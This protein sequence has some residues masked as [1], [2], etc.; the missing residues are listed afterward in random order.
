MTALPEQRETF[1]PGSVGPASSD[2]DL[3]AWRDAASTGDLPTPV[4]DRW[5]VLRCG[6]VN[7]WEF[8]VAEYWF[9]DGRAQFVGQNQSG[10]STLMALTTLIML[11]GDLDR[12]LVDTFGMQHKSFRYYVEPTDDPT[13]RRGT[14]HGTARGWAWVEY[15]RLV[16]GEP[17]YFTT[18][19]Y[20]QAK[21]GANDY[22]KAWATCEGSARVGDGLRLHRNAATAQP[23]DLTDV[24]GYSTASGGKEYKLRVSQRLF[25]FEDTERL[26][27]VVRMLKVLR[28][29]HLGQKLDPD[30]FTAR[31]R[32]A[33][34]AVSKSEIDELAE[35]WEQ[36]DRLAADRDSAQNARDAVSAYVRRAWNP[37][38]DSVL[39]RHADVLVAANTRQDSIA[40]GVRDAEQTLAGAMAG[41]QD[42]TARLDAGGREL[43]RDDASYEQLLQSRAYLDAHDATANVER[44]MLAARSHRV[45]A[46]NARE[47][48]GEGRLRV[49]SR[50]AT[51]AHETEA[52]TGLRNAQDDAVRVVTADALASGLPAE[53]GQ[54]A[55]DV[56]VARLGAAVA[57]RHEHLGVARRL[58]GRA[59]RASVAEDE[60]ARLAR[61]A[62]TELARR[63][64]TSEDAEAT[65]QSRLQELSD[66]LEQ[67]A[68]FVGVDAPDGAERSSWV[69]AVTEQAGRAAPR[70]VLGALLRSRWLTPTT[71]P[72]REQ[73]ALAD[74]AALELSGR[75][76]GLDMQVRALLD[77]RD[78]APAAPTRWTRRRR[79][80]HGRA[81][82][83]LWRLLDPSPDLSPEHLDRIEAALD[84]CGLL[85]AWVTPDGA[86]LP[87]RDGFDTVVTLSGDDAVASGPVPV[88]HSLSGPLRPAED[89]G[90]CAGTI[91]ALLSAVGFSLDGDLTSSYAIAADGR[92]R[93]PRSCGRA[94]PAEHGAELIGTAARASTRARKVAELRAEATALRAR[95]E[96]H[97]SLVTTLRSRVADL[98]AAVGRAPTDDAVV[99]AGL[100]VVA[101]RRELEVARGREA[102][103]QE[104]FLVAQAAAADANTSCSRS[105]LIMR[106]LTTSRDWPQ[107]ARRSPGPQVPWRRSASRRPGWRPAPTARP[108]LSPCSAR[109]RASSSGSSRP[110]RR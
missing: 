94:A 87:A 102:R 71:T 97:R 15:S 99:H 30:F 9:A 100:A 46:E 37:W 13:D 33:L 40:R 5:Q 23:G 51:L 76:V 67:W 4:R 70:S 61:D 86:Y 42:L 69:H 21:R 72:L 56:D 64:A 65:L 44:L 29:P 59:G 79:P 105:P 84:A 7:L 47:A 39:R 27:A 10:K 20:A 50:D 43:E 96:E 8:D 66:R 74:Q 108:V 19:L 49:S 25:G 6:V 45:L 1:V 54:W 110:R 34:P 26:D 109:R 60:A 62:G 22:V 17:T 80:E 53:C 57:A 81:G 77:E 82:A 106:W 101:A 24:A 3:A 14:E 12:A 83:P 63:E 90:E 91:T 93:S 98:E 35:G 92:W 48:R 38:A 36:L 68:A 2:A 58:L 103:A 88:D 89:A 107:S 16:D 104:R 18:L 31:M 52:L 78:P 55:V 28:T 73:A 85:D 11:A 95:A 41:H 32:E 75:A